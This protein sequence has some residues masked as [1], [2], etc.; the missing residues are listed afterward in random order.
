M[1]ILLDYDGT[2]APIAPNPNIT[3]MPIEVEKALHKLVASPR[4]FAAVI[5]GRGIV[6]VQNKVGIQNITYGGNHGIEIQN[7]DGTRKDYELPAEI[8]ANYTE[9]VTDLKRQLVKNGAWVEDKRVSLTYHYRDTPAKL[10]D[11]Q[12]L[13][14]VRII[15]SYGFRANQ[16][17]FAIEAKPPVNW[18]KGEATRFILEQKFG[19]NYAT[20]KNLKI[21]F[22]GDDT[23][24][25]D[26]MRVGF[27]ILT[28]MKLIQC[29]F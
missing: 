6:D 15:E 21:V 11:E 3:S 10:I 23:T 9:L 17:H 20:L 1:A 16:A 22:A 5:S 13:E 12:R 19:K 26:A 4:V 2:L 18:N 29:L 28:H 25:E 27:T 7:P 24:D 14:A 8:H